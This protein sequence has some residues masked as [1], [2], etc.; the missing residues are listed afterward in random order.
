MT[1]MKNAIR[2]FILLSL[3]IPFSFWAYSHHS[4][5]SS[6]HQVEVI[7]EDAVALAKVYDDKI[8]PD[9]WTDWKFY[10]ASNEEFQKEINSILEK[11]VG[12]TYQESTVEKSQKIARYVL[13]NLDKYRATPVYAEYHSAF[14]LWK[15]IPQGKIPVN[16]YEFSSIY[17][18]FASHANIP[19]RLV[20]VDSF[21]MGNVIH[22]T[23][24]ESYSRED[25]KW[26][27]VDLTYNILFTTDKEAHLLSVYDYANMLAFAPLNKFPSLIAHDLTEKFELFQPL[28][29]AKLLRFYDQKKYFTPDTTLIYTSK[30]GEKFTL[31][32]KEKTKAL[33]AA[34]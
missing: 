20:H 33:G 31:H 2:V 7:D 29:E 24:A 22:H 28:E 34:Q 19:V 21:F 27:M 1:H 17:G 4:A 11:K 10:N 13:Q 18:M 32:M 3:L 30:L 9:E 14:E 5:S 15:Q 26:F 8:L 16:C 25:G 12:I 23:V 6:S